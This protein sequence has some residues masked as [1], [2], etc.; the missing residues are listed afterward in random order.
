MLNLA[1]HAFSSQEEDKLLQIIRHGRCVVKLLE[2]ITV[3]A[4]VPLLSFYFQKAEPI[5]DSISRLAVLG[6]SK[7]VVGQSG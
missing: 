3:G 1:A 6:H 7:A 4:D 5:I 2:R